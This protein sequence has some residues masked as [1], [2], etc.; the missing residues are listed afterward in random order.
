LFGAPFF[1]SPF[2]VFIIRSNILLSVEVVDMMVSAKK[3][4]NEIANY[5]GA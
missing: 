4:Q 1:I 3:E 2:S 5:F